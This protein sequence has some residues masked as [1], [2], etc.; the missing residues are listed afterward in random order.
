MSDK[1]AN[2]LRF[3]D[4][5]LD[6][7]SREFRRAGELVS[8]EPRVFALLAFLFEQRHRAVDKDEIQEAV[9]KGT[10]VSE[11]A[12]TR[13]IQSRIVT[14]SGLSSSSNSSGAPPILLT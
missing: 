3:G 12:M 2:L 10:I 11:T 14:S 5:E 6:L 8:I 1:A 9:W 7:A 13:A 4:C